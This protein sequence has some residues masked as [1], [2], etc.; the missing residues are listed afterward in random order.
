MRTAQQT[1]EFLQVP[2]L[3]WLLACPLLCNARSTVHGR[4]GHRHPCRGADAVSLGPIQKTFEILQV[5]IIDKVFDVS[6][7]Q[8]Q[9]VL[10]CRR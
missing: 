10:G 6:V 1:V 8:V 2:F 3:D 7:V 9:Q 4:Q 5:Q